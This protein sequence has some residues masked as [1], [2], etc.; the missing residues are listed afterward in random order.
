MDAVVNHQWVGVRRLTL[1]G[2]GIIDQK[3]PRGHLISLETGAQV[4]SLQ[5]ERH[6]GGGR[7][8]LIHEKGGMA[9]TVTEK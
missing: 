7:V 5:M 9:D 3:E 2:V 6:T 8:E 1:R 4:V